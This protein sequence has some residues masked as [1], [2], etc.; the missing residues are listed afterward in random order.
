[1]FPVYADHVVPDTQMVS[2]FVFINNYI[3]CD[4][5]CDFIW[6]YIMNTTV[7]ELLH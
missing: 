3:L 5:D 2:V 4:N 6:H 7:S 1:M